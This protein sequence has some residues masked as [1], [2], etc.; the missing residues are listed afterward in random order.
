M[1]LYDMVLIKENHID[2]CGQLIDAVARV[3][4][5]WGDRFKIEVE[6][7]NFEEVEQALLA[8]VDRIMLDNMG[9]EHILEAV[10]LIGGRVETEA[11]GSINL[12]NV[13]AIAETGVDF[14]SMGALT[15]SFQCMD[16]SKILV[17]NVYFK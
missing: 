14:I 1:G 2:G 13:A 9:V 4:N 6:T 3:R 7:R 12:H 8:I 5:R 11:S 10:A 15:H 16:F 17:K